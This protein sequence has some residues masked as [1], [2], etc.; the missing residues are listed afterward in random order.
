[1]VVVLPEAVIDS[2]CCH[3]VGHES[4]HD[5]EEAQSDAWQLAQGEG[6]QTLGGD[7]EVVSLVHNIA[8]A[9]CSLLLDLGSVTGCLWWRV[10]C[11]VR[12]SV[13]TQ[14]FTISHLTLT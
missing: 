6:D 4:L 10:S 8:A 9:C 7:L 1:M 3:P 5:S 14:S 11:E 2:L 12:W 13:R